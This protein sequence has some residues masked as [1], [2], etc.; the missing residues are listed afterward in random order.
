MKERRIFRGM[1][2]AV[3]LL[4][5]VALLFASCSSGTGGGTSTGTPTVLSVDILRNGQP[6]TGTLTF[7]QGANVQFTASVEVTGGADTTVVW[8]KTGGNTETTLSSTGL[9]KIDADEPDDTELTITATSAFDAEMYASITVLVNASGQGGLEP[10]D[11]D[12]NGVVSLYLGGFLSEDV[13]DTLLAFASPETDAPGIEIVDDTD[14]KFGSEYFSIKAG[15]GMGTYG[16][17]LQLIMRPTKKI[18]LNTVN[19]LTFWARS[20]DGGAAQ[21]VEFGADGTNRDYAVQY[22]G[23]VWLNGIQFTNMWTQ[24]VIPLPKRI[25]NRLVDQ[26]FYMYFDQNNRNKTIYIDAIEFI[27]A[28]VSLKSVILQEP[29][30]ISSSANTPISTLTKGMKAIYTVDGK[31]VTLFIEGVHFDKFHTV[32]YNATGTLSVN[33][34]NLVPSGAGAF[35]FTVTIDGTITDT[36]N[37]V[38]GAAFL[39]LE[40]CL[41]KENLQ[42]AN[43]ATIGNVTTD[44]WWAGSSNQN[45]RD[46]LGVLNRRWGGGVEPENWWELEGHVW[47]LGAWDLS[48]YA[49]L[50]FRVCHTRESGYTPFRFKVYLY[51]GGIGNGNVYSCAPI[52]VTATT[53]W[54]DVV[55]N[56]NATTFRQGDTGTEGAY[57]TDFSDIQRWEIATVQNGEVNAFLYWTEIRAYE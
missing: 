37:S 55:L 40:D 18:N 8:S 49:E 44:A 54:Q 30:D 25:N 38:A 15:P 7:V 17:G 35:S 52:T 20:P 27:T 12:P 16:S 5:G 1:A 47:G 56:L 42:E 2:A 13:D 4:I 51:S 39:V 46:C 26:A 23:D 50:R 29:E 33:G 10:P 9:L 53:T 32:A 22:R 45:G 41:G 11:G 36:V 57:L 21:Y 48:S 43:Q 28:D 24:Y 3:T 31:D 34:N 19:A 6:V 14:S